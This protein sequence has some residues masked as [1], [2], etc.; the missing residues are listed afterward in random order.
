MNRNSTTRMPVA[1]PGAIRS[2]RSAGREFKAL[3]WLIRHPLF[4]LVPAALVWAL[5]NWGWPLVAGLLAG[6][7]VALL[8]WH[9]GYPAT[10][11]TWAAPVLRTGWRRWTAYRGGR[12]RR[13]LD[14]C[15]LV[16]EH[17]R[18]GAATYPAV[19]KVRAVTPSIDVLNV[20]VAPGQHL[21]LWTDRLPALTEALCAERVAITRL[22]P[23]M[24]TLVVERRMPFTQI[25]DA[26]E[27][28][29]SAAEVDVYAIV[30]GED[31]YGRPFPMRVRGKH[32]LTVGGSGAGK[33]GPMWN[34]LRGLAPMI[35][36]GLTRVTMVDLKGGTETE[37]GQAAFARWATTMEE[38]LDALIAFRDSMKA[39]QQWMRA[40]GVRTCPITV[41]T[42]L[43]LLV[44]DEMAMM[45]AYGDKRLVR[46]ALGLLAEI[47]TQGRAADHTVWGFV[48]EPT[49]DVVDV[50]D[51]FNLRLCLGV[52]AASHVDMALGDGARDRG[53]LADEIPGDLDHA[54]IG[55]AINPTTRMPVRFRAGLVEDHEIAEFARFCTTP[56]TGPGWL[57]AVPTTHTTAHT[58]DREGRD[59]DG[60][61]RA[62]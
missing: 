45:T 48:Q 2:V 28:P 30:I 55:F 40:H 57:V 31:E 39:R 36:D 59:H 51:L 19:R 49:K 54:G 60:E 16:H 62:S 35:R 47:L 43:E 15:D 58:P 50:R 24:V 4:A 34:G 5:A 22:R 13:L 3:G 32:L 61:E 25:I 52:N 53:A 1:R 42:P 6:L 21:A 56:P 20:R 7:G 23:G 11:D 29:E 44:I 26:T 33:S 12:W 10:F 14:D 18:T 27:M 37:L 17:R 9:R 38:A 46:D 8:G 41:E